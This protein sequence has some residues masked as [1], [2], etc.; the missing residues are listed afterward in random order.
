MG[1]MM[2]ENGSEPEIV[3]E[4]VYQAATD[5]NAPAALHGRAG[6]GHDRAEPQGIR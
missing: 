3:S 4:V 1:T 6:R 2:A 5:W